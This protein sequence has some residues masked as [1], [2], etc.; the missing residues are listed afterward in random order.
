ML[1]KITKNLNDIPE[2]KRPY[3]GKVFKVIETIAGK[4]Q[5]NKN[6]RHMIEVK[7]QQIYVAPDEY[8]V[9]GV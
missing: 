3:K 5:P 9:V 7:G 1:I 4:Y 8:D 6:Y 2:N